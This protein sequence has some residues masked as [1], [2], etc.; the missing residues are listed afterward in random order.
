MNSDAE[1][2]AAFAGWNEHWKVNI[3][4]DARILYEWFIAQPECEVWR[5]AILELASLDKARQAPWEDGCYMYHDQ[6]F[7][8][9]ARDTFQ[10]V[11]IQSAMPAHRFALQSVHADKIF[12]LFAMLI[13][14]DVK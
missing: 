2:K 7:Y 14:G 8:P 9:F 11:I 1:I 5:E 10:V 13:A 6:L 4:K 3:E 12:D